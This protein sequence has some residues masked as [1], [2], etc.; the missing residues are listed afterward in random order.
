MLQTLASRDDLEAATGR[1]GFVVVDECHHIPAVAF[2]R[3]ARRISARRWLGLTATPYRRDRLDELIAFHVGPVR[4]T[5]VP[6]KSGTIDAAAEGRPDLRL[7]VHRTSFTDDVGVDLSA[8]RAIAALRRALAEHEERNEQIVRDVD[9]ALARRRNCLV[10]AERKAHVDLLAERLQARGRT[11]VVL[12]GGMG[13]KARTHAMAQLVAA[14]DGPLLAVATG[15]F[16]GE[17]FDC[18][19]LDTLFLAAPVSFKG[20]IVQYVGRVLRVYPGKT[21]VEVHDYHDADVPVLAAAL[22]KRAPGYLSLGFP[23]PRRIAPEPPP[24]PAHP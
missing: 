23:D 13:V 8:P 18:P 22:G 21:T 19:A 24:R 15:S 2:E 12:M 11:P 10:L 16:V 1:Y 20:R 17:G 7:V 9:E 3:A 4:H 14:D 6:P 5:L